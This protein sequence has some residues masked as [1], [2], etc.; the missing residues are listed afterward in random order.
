MKTQ[1][2]ITILWYFIVSSSSMRSFMTLFTFSV[3]KVKFIFNDRHALMQ[4]SKSHVF[5]YIIYDRH[6][7]VLI[8]NK[9]RKFSRAVGT[10]VQIFLIYLR[11][12]ISGLPRDRLWKDDF[13][14]NFIDIKERIVAR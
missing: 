2:S 11:F 1:S 12:E 8:T 3:N 5:Q 10:V 6:F 9:G 14:S 4:C 7:I 13:L